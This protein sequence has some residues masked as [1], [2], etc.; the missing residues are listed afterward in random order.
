MAKSAKKIEKKQIHE[1]NEMVKLLKIVV[2]LTIIFGAFYLLTTIITK[3]EEK[4]E[5]NNN[6]QET[7]QYNQI[8]TGNIFSKKGN[9]YVLVESKDDKNVQVYEAYLSTYST[10]KDAKKVYISRLDDILNLKY[11]GQT[12]NLTTELS[13]LKFANT[14]LLEIKD[15][16]IVKSYTNDEE[17]RNVV[18]EI[19]GL[20]EEK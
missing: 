15:G 4:L 5:E 20:K 17:I 10:Q 14:V 12:T 19:S 3:E 11:V 16:Q 13:E 7:I 9:Y 6:T 18:K 8:L 2:I 1:E